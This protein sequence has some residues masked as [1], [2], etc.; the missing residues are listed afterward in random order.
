M[1]SP[2]VDSNGINRVGLALIAV[3]DGSGLDCRGRA[4]HDFDQLVA[5]RIVREFIGGSLKAPSRRRIEVVNLDRWVSEF[6][7]KNGLRLEDHLRG[8]PLQQERVEV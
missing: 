1:A 6:L 8:A 7:R 5:A 3:G 4:V 2:F